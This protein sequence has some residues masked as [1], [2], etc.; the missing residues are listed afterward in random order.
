MPITEQLEALHHP[1]TALFPRRAA[2]IAHAQGAIHP[3]AGDADV[4]RA[5]PSC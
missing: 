3:A 5:L 4:Q 1:G 2:V